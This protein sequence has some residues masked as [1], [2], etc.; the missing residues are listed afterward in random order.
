M[1]CSV[2][3]ISTDTAVKNALEY[4]FTLTEEILRL[5]CH[6]FLHILGYDHEQGGRKE[7]LMR[8]KEEYYLEKAH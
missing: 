3:Y 4:G 7:K 6:G 8:S 5:C 1:P 2:K